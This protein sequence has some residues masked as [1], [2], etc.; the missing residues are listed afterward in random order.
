MQQDPR[1]LNDIDEE[2]IPVI[3][4]VSMIT[5]HDDWIFVTKYQCSD[6]LSCSL[7]QYVEIAPLRVSK[8][9]K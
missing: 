7:G 3:K 8:G 1:P 5:A 6:S 9:E 4:H 2:N